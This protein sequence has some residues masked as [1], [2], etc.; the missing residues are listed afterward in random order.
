MSAAL[1]APTGEMPEAE[2]LWLEL[3]PISSTAPRRLIVF[4]HGAGSS[5]ERFAPVA[6][7]WMLKFPGATGAILHALRP[8]S[9]GAGGDWFDGLGPAD[10]LAPRIVQAGRQVA[11]RIEM[12]QQ[13]TG[14][15]GESTVVI[16]FSQGA[17]LALEL[18][19]SRPDLL[20]IAV[21]YSGRMIPPPRQGEVMAP[22][23]HLLHGGMDSVVP[24]IHAQ[25]ACRRLSASGARV[26]LDVLEEYG[27]SIGQDMII[28]GTTRVM[29][30][31]F[32][33][34]RPK[35]SISGGTTLH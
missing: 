10:T 2:A 19:R 5:A 21:S 14:V 8:A 1:N 20:G 4:L 13:T 26:T 29:Q 3:P 11:E 12:L 15:G 16:G 30:T 34:R 33:D 32:R 28:L 25:Q 24:V 31:L 22:A 7:A 17:T 18:A 6:I 9:V 35:R 27:H 23:I